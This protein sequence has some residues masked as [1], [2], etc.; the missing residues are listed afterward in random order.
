MMS[1]IPYSFA[2][3]STRV[4]KGRKIRWVVDVER[5]GQPKYLY[6]ILE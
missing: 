2:E 3:P 5:I 1:F 6:N 4:I